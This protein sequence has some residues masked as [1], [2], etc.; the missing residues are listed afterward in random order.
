MQKTLAVI[1]IAALVAG[2]ASNHKEHSGSPGANS[3][4][5]VGG[6]SG[7]LAAQDAT[8]IQEAAQGGMTEVREGQLAQKNT[9]N[10]AVRTF[11]QRLITDHGKANQELRQIAKNKG[12]AVP[13]SLGK[14]Q[15][16]YD[17]LAALKDAD[18]DKAFKEQSIKDHQGAIKLFE[19]QTQQ[20]SDADLKAFAQKH[21]PHLREHLAM[22]Q[23]LGGGGQTEATPTSGTTD[24]P[25][26]T[27]QQ[28]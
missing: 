6:A 1:S 9:Q 8:F 3:Q 24:S 25:S 18:F 27:T 2:C 22:A 19:Q 21:L 16:Q 11:G 4:E 17:R 13:T 20:G 14:N 26:S 10:D 23:Q 28:K 12:A 5:T 7:T 15:E